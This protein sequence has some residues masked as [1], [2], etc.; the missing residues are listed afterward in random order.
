MEFDLLI[1]LL[2]SDGSIIINKRLAR[3]LGIDAAIMYSELASKYKY[4]K[5][6]DE[7][8]KDGFFFNTV[9]NMQED[10]TLS[11]YQ[12]NKA[13]KVLCK[14]GLIN[15]VN[16]GLPQKRYFKIVNDLELLN[17][18][19]K[20][21]DMTKVSEKL[22]NSPIRSEKNKPIKG[23]KLASN[24]TKLNKTKTNNTKSLHHLE[25]LNDEYAFS[26]LN[27]MKQYGH[28]QKKLTDK[29]IERIKYA[30][31]EIKSNDIDIDTWEDEVIDHFETLAEGRCGDILL[32]LEACRRHFDIQL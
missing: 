7:L 8:T 13:L 1:E 14:I 20:G 19:L 17:E 23:E 27:I 4:F 3:S 21:V 29:S 26:Y 22:K 16:R 6:K 5:N 30:L 12:Q 15:Q 24:N 31:N 28:K 11:K 10:T 18:C 9:D 32:F 2:R 25:E